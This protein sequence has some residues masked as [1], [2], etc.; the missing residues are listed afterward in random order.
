MDC[1]AIDI[2]VA[3]AKME[4]LGKFF[5]EHLSKTVSQDSIYDPILSLAEY[6]KFFI[7]GG[8]TKLETWNLWASFFLI[9]RG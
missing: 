8:Q 7:D 4:K 9:A 3:Y 1:K 5:F 6:C 2:C